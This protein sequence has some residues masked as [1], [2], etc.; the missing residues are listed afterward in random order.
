MSLASAPDGRPERNRTLVAVS[1][2]AASNQINCLAFEA[3]DRLFSKGKFD[4]FA[5]LF[6]PLD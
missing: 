3:G 2:F 1:I 5:V 6:C 4:F